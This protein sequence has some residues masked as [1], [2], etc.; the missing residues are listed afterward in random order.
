MS[1]KILNEKLFCLNDGGE[2]SIN[3]T[4]MQQKLEKIITKLQ[5][6]QTAGPDILQNLRNIAVSEIKE[7]YAPI[8]KSLKDANDQNYNLLQDKLKLENDIL[9]LKDTIKAFENKTED[10]EEVVLD[11]CAKRVKYYECAIWDKNHDGCDSC[12]F[13]KGSKRK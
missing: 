2:F 8:V 3:Y 13:F 4:I 10:F 7:V 12:D 11:T 1:I 6:K 9:A 5:Q